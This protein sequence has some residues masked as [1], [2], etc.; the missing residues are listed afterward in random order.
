MVFVNFVQFVWFSIVELMPVQ[1]LM[2]I[3]GSHGIEFWIE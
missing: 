2:K 1:Y 3:I